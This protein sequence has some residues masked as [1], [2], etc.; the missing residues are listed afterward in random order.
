MEGGPQDTKLLVLPSRLVE[1][2]RA[3]A[4]RRGLSLSNYA[5]EALEQA[6]RAEAMGAPLRDAVDLY[7]LGEVQRGA[8]AV[9]L[10]RSSLERLVVELY[11]EMGEELRGA[12]SEAGRW[13]GAYLRAKLRGADILAFLERALL[14]SWNLDEAEVRDKGGAVAL[15][16]T[17][18]VLSLES[19]ELLLSYVSGAMDSLGYDETGR[20]IM[21]GMARARYVRKRVR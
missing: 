6:L 18:F 2:L 10:P 12:W 14:V 21:R 16:L 9:Q 8:G 17:S 20:D 1:R 11:P 5:V 13:Y 15:R 4:A 7:L 19:T 3:S